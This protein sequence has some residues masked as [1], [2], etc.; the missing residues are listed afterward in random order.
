MS[1][2]FLRL[3][4]RTGRTLSHEALKGTRYSRVLFPPRELLKPQAGRWR[5]LPPGGA[6]V[7]RLGPE[8]QSPVPGVCVT[9]TGLH[10]HAQKRT[11]PEVGGPER[12]P[13]TF[14]STL[15]SQ[16][17]IVLPFQGKTDSREGTPG[18]VLARG[19]E[20]S[21]SDWPSIPD[22]LVALPPPG[23]RATRDT[24]ARWAP[25]LPAGPACHTR[26]RALAWRGLGHSRLISSR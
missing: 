24:R 20:G 17:A 22:S 21:G 10:T 13:P 6:R 26:V 19:R 16:M 11:Y 9:P 18:A 25:A 14:S 15:A 4:T 23:P 1:L 7:P 12:A 2:S 5:V 8:D 3:Q